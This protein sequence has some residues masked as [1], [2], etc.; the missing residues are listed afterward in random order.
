MKSMY[1]AAALAALLGSAASAETIGVSMQ[2]F[3][4]NFQTL[5]RAGA[6]LLPAPATF[7]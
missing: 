7:S 3:D 4:N 5:L 6:F 1:L 2:S